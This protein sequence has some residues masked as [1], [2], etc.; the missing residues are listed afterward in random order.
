MRIK[1]RKLAA[2]GLTRLLTQSAVMFSEPAINVWY[3]S[4]LVSPTCLYAYLMRYHRSP[5]FVALSK[6]F[7][8]IIYLQAIPNEQLTFD[9]ILVA[10]R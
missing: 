8:C 2:V 9:L 10:R 6:L 7:S 4:S 5:A 1:D 3:V